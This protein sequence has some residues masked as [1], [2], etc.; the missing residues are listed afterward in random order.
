MSKATVR[1]Y[2]ELNDFLPAEKRKRDFTVSFDQPS[3]VK[4]VIQ[5]LGVPLDDID[6]VLVDGTPVGFS[7][8]LRGGERISVYPVFESLDIGSVTGLGRGPLRDLRFVADSQLGELAESLR[9]FGFDC[10]YDNNADSRNLVK[11]SIQQGRV[12]L[13]QDSALLNCPDITRGI[14]IRE[15]DPGE[16]LKQVL[17]RLDLTE[18]IKASKSTKSQAPSSKQAPNSNT[19]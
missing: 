7:Y 14:L 10:L 9:G 3:R 1:F 2:E 8:P 6:L 4:N 19:Q 13:T 15:T 11:M 16:Q 17:E 18:A 12:L 5:S